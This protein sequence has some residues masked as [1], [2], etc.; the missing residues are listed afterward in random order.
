MSNVALAYPLANGLSYLRLVSIYSVRVLFL[1][2]QTLF[3]CIYA[4]I[5]LYTTHTCSD[6]RLRLK[7]AIKGG[8]TPKNKIQLQLVAPRGEEQILKREGEVGNEK[9]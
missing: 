8:F 5:H 6:K 7:S 1:A 3:S 4:Y 9:K 2:N